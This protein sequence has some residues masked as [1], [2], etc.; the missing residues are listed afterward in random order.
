MMPTKAKRNKCT[1]QPSSFRAKTSESGCSG[2]T[3]KT[4]K[5]ASNSYRTRRHGTTKRQHRRN[6]MPA[7]TTMSFSTIERF[8]TEDEINNTA[9]PREESIL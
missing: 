1:A 8:D 7:T 5:E 9:S 2:K 4:I 6:S 3:H